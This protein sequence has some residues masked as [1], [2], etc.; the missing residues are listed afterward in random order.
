MSRRNE[1]LTQLLALSPTKARQFNLSS[2]L[3]TRNTPRPK[4][5]MTPRMPSSPSNNSPSRPQSVVA[6][7]TTTEPCYFSPKQGSM[8]TPPHVRMQDLAAG[9]LQ[10]HS[11]PR[12][13]TG[14][15]SRRS[16]IASEVSFSA[17]VPRS[18]TQHLELFGAAY[19][20]A[21]PKTKNPK[22]PPRST[23]LKPLLLPTLTGENGAL[24]SA[25]T[26]SPEH[27]SA[28]SPGQAQRREFS[29]ESID[30]TTTFLSKSP[31]QCEPELESCAFSHDSDLI[32][33]RQL[34]Y[35]S[36]EGVLDGQTMADSNEFMSKSLN[37]QLEQDALPVGSIDVPV[38]DAWV[39][40]QQTELDQWM[41]DPEQE[42]GEDFDVTIL[43]SHLETATKDAAEI[44]IAP[45]LHSYPYPGGRQIS[46]EIP[47]PLFSPI[48]RQKIPEYFAAPH[49]K[50]WGAQP[51]A[52]EPVPE[53]ASSS[54]ESSRKAP[55]T[56]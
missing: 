29:E 11:P 47:K 27:A 20:A 33:S 22:I 15:T 1:V 38:E 5:M 24:Y 48:G 10:L 56:E 23:Q 40:S 34:A 13:L 36:L 51:R 31:V 45:D 7:P 3:R 35:Q 9:D 17:S 55:K 18:P 26:I 12:S 28:M 21:K 43:P 16:T 46:V 44:D 53:I 41:Y 42:L 19:E 30:P 39:D 2:P 50:G 49:P 8:S 32:T 6:S 54:T 52:S 4:S 14:S 37:W 25:S